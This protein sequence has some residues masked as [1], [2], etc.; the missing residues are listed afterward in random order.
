MKTSTEQMMKSVVQVW[1]YDDEVRNRCAT[2]VKSVPRRVED[3]I[4]A[5]EEHT[6]Y[7]YRVCLVQIKELSETLKSIMYPD[8]T[9]FDKLNLPQFDWLENW[10]IFEMQL[11][12]F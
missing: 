6:T 1:F 11:S 12:D 9:S 5:L 3:V 4:S 2:L 8:E 10:R 7:L